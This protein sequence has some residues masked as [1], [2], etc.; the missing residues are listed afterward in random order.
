MSFVIAETMRLAAMTNDKNISP[1]RRGAA[2][3]L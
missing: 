3:K 1:P 2:I